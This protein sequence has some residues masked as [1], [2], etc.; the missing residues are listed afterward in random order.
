MCS[1]HDVVSFRKLLCPGILPIFHNIQVQRSVSSSLKY[2]SVELTMHSYTDYL[3]YAYLHQP[4]WVITCGDIT[5][6]V[7]LFY[8]VC[9]ERT[10]AQMLRPL[11]NNLLTKLLLWVWV[12]IISLAQ[13]GM[14]LSLLPQPC[15]LNNNF[16]LKQT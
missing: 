10:Y 4:D 6:I 8:P 5:K 2:V 14:L 15:F 13:S 1:Y 7:P 12:H 16:G 3:N 11:V 9:P